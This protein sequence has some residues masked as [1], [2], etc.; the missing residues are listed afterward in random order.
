[1]KGP[2]LPVTQIV[3]MLVYLI[4]GSVLISIPNLP[5]IAGGID[6]SVWTIGYVGYAYIIVASLYYAIRGK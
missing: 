2:K 1:M 4:G 6:I 3:L 5:K